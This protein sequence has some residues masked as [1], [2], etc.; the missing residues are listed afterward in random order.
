[1]NPE[2]YNVNIKLEAKDNIYKDKLFWKANVRIIGT[3]KDVIKNAAAW[4]VKANSNA[5]ETVKGGDEVVFKDGAGVK[6]T[7]SGKE[8]TISADTT[9][10]SKDTKISYTANGAAPKKEVSLAD[11]F[12]FEDGNLTTASVDTAGKVKYDVKTTTLTSTDGKV[13]VPTTDGVATAKDVANAI[14]NSGWKANAGGNVDGTSASTLV[15]AGDEVVF[16]AGDNLTVKQ[17]LTAGK[18]EYT[19]KLNKDLKDLDSVTSKTI[20]VPGAPGTNSVVIGKD[21]I[22]AGDKKITNVA[23]GVNGTDAVNKN[24]LDQIGD[25]TIKLGGDNTT[26]TAGQKLSKTG[27]LQFN[28]KGANGIETSAA[29]YC[30]CCQSH[31]SSGT[32]RRERVKGRRCRSSTSTAFWRR[33]RWAWATAR[34]CGGTSC[35]TA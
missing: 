34:L 11:G 20:T 22:N 14:N 3:G 18:Q 23:P 6:I 17:D 31:P 25:N 10:I 33:V 32:S 19:Y 1:L 8:F 2:I 4:K 29:G 12:N 24:Q 27:G 5:A 16:K 9:K 28:I 15:K 26:V 7:Q 30:R 21:G 13:T 35:P